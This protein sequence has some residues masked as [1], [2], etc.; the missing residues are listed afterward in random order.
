MSFSVS[1]AL[2]SGEGLRFV[3]R[4]R[5]WAERKGYADMRV[6]WRDPD[7]MRPQSAKIN[8]AREDAGE[9]LFVKSNEILLRQPL[10][11]ISGNMSL[12]LVGEMVNMLE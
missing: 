9:A 1:K 6:R 7:I 11:D 8:T 12:E 2:P 10:P 5:A 3:E 4:V